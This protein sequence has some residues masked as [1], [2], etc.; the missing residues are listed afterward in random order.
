MDQS[1]VAVGGAKGGIPLPSLYW[2]I[3]GLV[4][5]PALAVAGLAAAGLALPSTASL[6]RLDREPSPTGAWSC[7]FTDK[8]AG[9]LVVNGWSYM[10]SVDGAQP[11]WGI[12][13]PVGG[14]TPKNNSALVHVESGPLKED[15]SIRV[16]L[17]DD[18][19]EAEN[20]IFNTGP[21]AGFQCLRP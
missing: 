3:A 18:K 9:T 17:Y 20:L 15:F 16:A 19:A 13:S 21:G 12:L 6:S 11:R 1:M 10:L 4:A 14:R 7:S 2:K 5:L 8:T